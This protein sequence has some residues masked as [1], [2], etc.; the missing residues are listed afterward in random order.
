MYKEFDWVEAKERNNL[1]KYNYLKNYWDK[2][3][4]EEKFVEDW[5]QFKAFSSLHAQ[6]GK[7]FNGLS[8]KLSKKYCNAY[9]RGQYRSLKR[10]FGFFIGTNLNQ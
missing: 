3:I 6:K 4:S 5:K 10:K 7:P 1:L 2:E 9:L 8:K